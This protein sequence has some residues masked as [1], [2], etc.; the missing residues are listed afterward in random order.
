MWMS[1]GWWAD[2]NGGGVL[3]EPRIG[4]GAVRLLGTI[5]QCSPFHRMPIDSSNEG[6]T[7]VCGR[8][9]H[10]PTAQETRV[11]NACEDLASTIHQSSA[12]AG[13][14]VMQFT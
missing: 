14:A 2:L 3:L 8:G 10:Y 13:T 4:L 7:C 5:A 9:E 11:R 1:D 6:S 12:R